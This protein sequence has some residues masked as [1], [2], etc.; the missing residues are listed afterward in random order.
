MEEEHHKHTNLKGVLSELKD[1]IELM[2]DL[3]YS[4]ILFDERYFGG[5]VMEL[6]E[7]VDGLV[8]EAGG[9][10]VSAARGMTET[11]D[12]VRLLRVLSI[13]DKIAEAASDI[14]EIK[15]KEIGLPS[16][17]LKTM[18]LL[19][20]TIVGVTIS[21]DIR[22]C[23]KTVSELEN[24][25]K[26]AILALRHGGRW[27]INP[28]GDQLLLSGDRIIAKGPFDA[29]D[30]FESY[31]YGR[32]SIF[33][34]EEE[35]NEPEEFRDIREMIVE[36]KNY[37]E[38]AVDLAYSSM[39]FR[40]GG[41][42][43]EVGMLE[44]RLDSL[45]RELEERVLRYAKRLEDPTPLAGVLHIAWSCERVSDAALELAESSLR[46]DL[47][48]SLLS[49]AFEESEEVIMRIKIPK[50][51]RLEGKTMAELD[52]EG[53]TGAQIIAIRKAG[54]ERW[55]YYPKGDIPLEA[56]DVL[57]LKGEKEFVDGFMKELGRDVQEA[58]RP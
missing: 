23:G 6:E 19:E 2:L 13:A 22:V 55:I 56:G 7:R 40:D 11:E 27:L 8:N 10:I 49:E 38:L 14:A 42:A 9:I 47:L 31:I 50:G 34:P 25:T 29:L 26:M 51:S 32:S 44:S 15:L 30:D 28:S 46:S 24:D 3:A 5:E 45:R 48:S 18:N 36:M 12:M 4:S 33:P 39:M 54:G 21:E 53:E 57:I 20:E 52:L 58:A 1:T 16:H 37:S 35:L 43:E 41:V 17:F